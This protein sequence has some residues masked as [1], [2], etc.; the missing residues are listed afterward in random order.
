MQYACFLAAGT[1]PTTILEGNKFFDAYDQALRHADS[2][3]NFL[4]YK[5]NALYSTGAKTFNNPTL[6]SVASAAT[7]TL[8]TEAEVIRVTGVTNIT[9]I[10]TNGHTGH[11]VT[12]LFDGILTVF[13]GSTIQIGTDFVTTEFDTITLVCDGSLWLEVSRSV[14]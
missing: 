9:T 6:P 7:I 8:P 2:I 10:D 5:N 3:T 1:Q 11:R 14:N 12:L 13:R 4:V